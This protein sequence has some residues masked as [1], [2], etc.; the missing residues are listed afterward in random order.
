VLRY[1]RFLSIAAEGVR[2]VPTEDIDRVWHAHIL[3]TDA[4][5]RDCERVFGFFFH[6]N[7]IAAEHAD[8]N[9]GDFAA[10]GNAYAARFGEAYSR[11]QAAQC[12]NGGCDGGSCNGPGDV[13]PVGAHVMLA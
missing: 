3:H 11:T 9:E 13:V 1:R 7:P 12:N 5:A 8:L 6:H 10:T 2:V 4:Y